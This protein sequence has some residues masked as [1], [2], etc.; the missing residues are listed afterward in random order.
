[1]VEPEIHTVPKTNETKFKMSFKAQKHVV[2]LGTRNADLLSQS[3]SPFLNFLIVS[4]YSFFNDF[5]VL[6]FGF[7]MQ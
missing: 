5:T 7:F 1:M 6:E 4:L 3:E 2:L